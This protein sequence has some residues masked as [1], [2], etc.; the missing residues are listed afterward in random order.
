MRFDETMGRRAAPL[1]HAVRAAR[2]LDPRVRASAPEHLRVRRY[3]LRRY[4]RGDAASSVCAAAAPRRHVT[5]CAEGVQTSP[6]AT[7]S[8]DAGGSPASYPPGLD[9][10]APPVDDACRFSATRQLIGAATD[11]IGAYQDCKQ[12]M[13]ERLSRSD[14]GGFA[15]F[16]KEYMEQVALP[17]G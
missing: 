11:G 4:A 10:P 6:S 8:P 5:C 16:L 2:R 1:F 13:L 9:L 3:R 17:G 14:P 12:R 7:G 15:S